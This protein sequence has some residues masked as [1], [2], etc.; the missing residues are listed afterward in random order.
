MSAWIS[1]GGSDDIGGLYMGKDQAFVKTQSSMSMTTPLQWGS[2]RGCCDRWYG[3]HNERKGGASFGSKGMALAH[4]VLE[5]CWAFYG[6]CQGDGCARRDGSNNLRR[7]K[8]WCPQRHTHTHID[9][10]DIATEGEKIKRI[11]QQKKQQLYYQSA[12]HHT[13]RLVCSWSGCCPKENISHITTPK[14]HIS[15]AVENLPV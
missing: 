7:R 8:G 4:E 12:M 10:E 14:A 1:V 3:L 9:C 5:G 13:C 11:A 6:H 2:I 15:L